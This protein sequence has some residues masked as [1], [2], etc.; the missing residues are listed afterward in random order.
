VNHPLG[1]RASGLL[2]SRPLLNRPCSPAGR[3]HRSLARP[4]ASGLPV[5]PSSDFWASDRTIL[6][7]SG[8]LRR[9]SNAACGPPSALP[10]AVC[11]S[12]PNLA[13]ILPQAR[14]FASDET[15]A[16]VSVAAPSRRAVAATVAAPWSS[17]AAASKVAT[18]MKRCQRRPRRRRRGARS[19]ET[20]GGVA[21]VRRELAW[22]RLSCI[23]I[24]A[25]SRV[26]FCTKLQVAVEIY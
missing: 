20:A 23:T 5:C 7:Y 2:L 21:E 8:M 9:P 25:T 16:A 19:R 3:N 17:V 12:L 14:G 1:I 26:K 10:P 18:G 6:L 15:A 24:S 4:A 22:R 13:S 11:S